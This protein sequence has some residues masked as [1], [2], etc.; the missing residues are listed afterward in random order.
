[1]SVLSAQ[2]IKSLGILNPCNYPYKDP[3]GNSAGLSACGYD[4][5]LAQHVEINPGQFKLASA[6]ERFNLPNN[7]VGIIHDKSSLARVGLVVQNTVAEPGWSGHL[8]LELTN[9]GSERLVFFVGCAI[10]QVV[11]HFLD[12][13]T[14][15]PYVGKYQNQGIE[16]QGP[17]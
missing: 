1:M 11:F 7:I 6:N 13:P 17:L 9:H 2:T 3:K 15:F 5:T 16:P 4:L 14:F 12:E 10:C 8:T